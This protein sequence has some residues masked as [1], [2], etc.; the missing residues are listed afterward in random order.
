MKIPKELKEA[1]K[2]LKPEDAEEALK[3]FLEAN[4]EDQAGMLSF[5]NSNGPEKCYRLEYEQ[6]IPTAHDLNT[7]YEL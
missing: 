4:E 3:E 2:L 7:Y 6:G 1:L 5:I